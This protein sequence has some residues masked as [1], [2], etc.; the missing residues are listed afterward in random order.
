MLP[1]TVLLR[2][3]RPGTLSFRA[4]NGPD[5]VGRDFLKVARSAIER[6]RR[7]GSA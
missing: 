6:H 3:I 5:E 2:R 7:R 1:D 4:Q